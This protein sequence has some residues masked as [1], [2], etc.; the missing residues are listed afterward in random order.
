MG[1]WTQIRF[2]AKV[3]AIRKPTEEE[4]LTTKNWVDDEKYIFTQDVGTG[5][6]PLEVFVSD[7]RLEV[8]LNAFYFFA[9]FGAAAAGG[10]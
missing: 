10:H 4:I 5:K 3:L 1:R 8:K 6:L 2:R 7:G 9:S